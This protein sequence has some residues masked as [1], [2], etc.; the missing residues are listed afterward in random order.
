MKI[1]LKRVKVGDKNILK[2]IIDNKY[3]FGGEPS[4]HF[5]FKDD[6]LIGDGM[7]TAIR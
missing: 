1:K 3:I 2:E 7:T 5:I 6:I 4:G